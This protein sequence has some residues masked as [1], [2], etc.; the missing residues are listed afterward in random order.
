MDAYQLLQKMTFSKSMNE[1]V[2]RAIRVRLKV[3]LD[4]ELKQ[5]DY[6]RAT[7]KPKLN[8]TRQ[9]QIEREFLK[10]IQAAKIVIHWLTP[11]FERTDD[12][13]TFVIRKNKPK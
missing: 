2:K 12:V 1:T 3:I 10:K 5:L 6:W 4:N 13:P 7:I 9:K 11:F 8:T